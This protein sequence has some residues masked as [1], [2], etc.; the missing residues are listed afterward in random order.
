MV[1][2]SLFN[3]GKKCFFVTNNST[4]TRQTLLETF[5]KVGINDVSENEIIGTSWVLARYLKSIDFKD[6]VYVIGSPAMGKELDEQG[7]KH[8]GFKFMHVVLEILLKISLSNK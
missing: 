3:I 1:S 2:T 7:I 4:K 5:E 6:K 8:T